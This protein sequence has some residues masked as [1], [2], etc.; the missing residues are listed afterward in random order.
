MRTLLCGEDTAQEGKFLVLCPHK[1]IL[2]KVL[3][4]PKAQKIYLGLIDSFLIC[5]LGNSMIVIPAVQAYF[6]RQ[7]PHNQEIMY[8]LRHLILSSDPRIVEE[9]KFNTPFYMYRGWL[10]YLNSRPKYVDLGFCRGA[11][12]SN[13]DGLLLTAN[14]KT[15]TSLRISEMIDIQEDRFREIIQEAMLLNE[16]HWNEKQ[17]KKNAKK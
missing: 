17:K 12:L 3:T 9:A 7:S 5:N 1:T 4:V 8:L 16:W 11:K 14:R 2:A 13:E 15:V 10:C 6:D